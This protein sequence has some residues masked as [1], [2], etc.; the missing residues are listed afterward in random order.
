MPEIIVS[1][2]SE[3]AKDKWK[4]REAKKH[5]WRSLYYAVLHFESYSETGEGR[6]ILC[7]DDGEIWWVDNRDVR[8]VNTEDFIG[9]K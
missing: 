9:N 6:V 5:S 4:R 7:N 2:S 8:V 1:F 3:K